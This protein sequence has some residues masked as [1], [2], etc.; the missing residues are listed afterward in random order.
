MKIVSI[1][2][3]LQQVTSGDTI[4]IGHAVGEPKAL[5][6]ALVRRGNELR[7]VTIT[8]M[9]NTRAAEYVDAKYASSFRH[10]S[11]F[12]GG[13][14]RKA[15]ADGRA[16]FTPCHFSQI[17]NLFNDGNIP[18]DV[19][20]IQVSPPD[21]H[22]FVSLGVSVDYTMALAK[23]AKLVIAQ[24]NKEMPRT[25]GDC[26]LHIEEID[27][28]VVWDEPLVEIP[29]SILTAE[30]IAIGKHC[31]AL[32]KD[33][34]TL[35]LG[36]GSLPDAVLSMLTDKQNL[37]IHS[38]LISDGVMDLIQCNVITNGAKTIHKGKI[39]ATF[40]MGTKELYSFIDDN[41]M[42]HMAPATYVNAPEVIAQNDNLVSINSCVQIDL[43]GQVCAESVGRKQ[44]SASG[45]QVDFVRGAKMSRG[46]RSIMAMASS[47]RG[48]TVS[49]IV[50]V[51]DEGAVVT[52]GRNEVH[53]VVTEN[54]V[55]DLH[56]QTLRERGRRLIQIAHENFKDDL[57][58][59]WENRYQM[60]FN[61]EEELQ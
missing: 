17:P 30:E 44:I 16:D 45:G 35:Q 19:A 6:D 33:G 23:N 41:P 29:R 39:V 28:G 43:T 50:D 2:E 13:P 21:R 34:D 57:I 5:V 24:I 36:I 31:A 14:I 40:V 37:G 48:G 32:I 9:I 8:H 58:A 42:V 47:A 46:G 3:A 1:E 54:G 56:G 25:L 10:N 27:Y 53:Y 61:E 55:A 22:G 60:S 18:L 52:T 11:L 59:S 51:L 7:G 49:K 4:G 12:V 38:E 26:F 20:L 15:V